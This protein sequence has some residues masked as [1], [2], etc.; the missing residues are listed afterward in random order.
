MMTS[1]GH[2]T[3]RKEERRFLLGEGR[4]AD[5]SPSLIKPMP[6][7][8]ACPTS[9]P[10]A[11]AA[12]KAIDTAKVAAMEGVVAI[13]TGADV[14]ANRLGGLPADGRSPIVTDNSWPSR[15]LL[16]WRPIASAM[17]ANTAEFKGPL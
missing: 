15:C 12:L 2:P 14:A 17:S 7:C 13:L 3:K 16:F 6:M 8:C 10:Y 1:I 11:H 4:S 9:S 5:A